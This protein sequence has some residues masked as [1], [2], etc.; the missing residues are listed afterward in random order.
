MAESSEPGALVCHPYDGGCNDCQAT[1]A[2]RPEGAIRIV[3]IEPFTGQSIT[4]G[5]KAMNV[6]RSVEAML[7]A[8]LRRSRRAEVLAV[9]R[10]AIAGARRIG[11]AGGRAA[12]NEYEKKEGP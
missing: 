5:I 12:N 7:K 11:F 1:S 9:P 10:I 6:T 8:A 2:K 3:S 4:I